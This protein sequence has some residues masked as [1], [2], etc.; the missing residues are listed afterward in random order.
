[1]QFGFAVSQPMIG[2]F[3]P[4]VRILVARG[5]LA[6]YPDGSTHPLIKKRKVEDPMIKYPDMHEQHGH[7]HAFM[8]KLKRLMG[9]QGPA[10][11]PEGAPQMKEGYEPLKENRD[12]RMG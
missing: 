4:G 6:N 10:R 3:V 12:W 8:D 5:G 7:S 2:S 11:S 9:H 1:M